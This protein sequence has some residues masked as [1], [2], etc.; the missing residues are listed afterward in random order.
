MRRN[1]DALR[2]FLFIRLLFDASYLTRYATVWH[3]SRLA[4]HVRHQA[5]IGQAP[6]INP[7]AWEGQ[8]V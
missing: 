7:A 2:L 8:E 3:A 5:K 4:V 6:Y 1:C